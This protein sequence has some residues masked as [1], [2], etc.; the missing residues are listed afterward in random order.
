VKATS[1]TGLTLTTAA[2]QDVTVTVPGTAKILVVAPGSR[3][4][5]SATSG[6]LS[7]IQPSDKVIVTGTPGETGSAVTAVRVILM[8][9]AA[10]AQTHA[11]EDAAWAQGVGGIAKSVDAASGKLVISNGASTW[12]VLTTPSTVVR[13]YADGSVRFADAQVSTLAAI[14]PGDQLRVRGTKDPDGTSITA[15]EMVAGTFRNYSGLIASVDPAAGTLTLKDLATKR[16]VSVEVTPNSDLRQLPP[17]VA[18]R[19]AASMKGGG[20]AGEPGGTGSGRTAPPG[21]ANGAPEEAGES[22][23]RRAGRAGMNLS[24]MLSRLPTETLADLKVGDAVM[25]VASASASDPSKSTAVTLLSGVDPILTAPSGSAT[26]LTPWSV[27]S[28]EPSESGGAEP[29]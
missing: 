23:S 1:A 20:A 26:T 8:K 16:T 14:R 5:K 11:A 21:P 28:P 17:S 2:G 10:I 4:L 15:D 6:S 12:T 24:Q 25:I 7:D 9:S 13:H 29:Q 22:D 27:G 3:D 19:V 18:Q